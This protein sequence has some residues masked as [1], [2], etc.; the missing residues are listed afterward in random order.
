MKSS[1]F[2]LG[3]EH[4][5]LKGKV[6]LEKHIR[7]EEWRAWKSLGNAEEVTWSYLLDLYFK[8]KHITRGAR[9]DSNTCGMRRGRNSRVKSQ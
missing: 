9:A 4:M 7:Y 2:L 5:F 6:M 3:T 8:R 1:D